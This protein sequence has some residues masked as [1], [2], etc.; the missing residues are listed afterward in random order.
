VLRNAQQPAADGTA[1]PLRR[2]RIQIQSE[3]AEVFYRNIAVRR[4]SDFPRGYAP[5]SIE[6]PHPAP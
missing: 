3:G 2:G 1:A 5:S 4:I 6:S